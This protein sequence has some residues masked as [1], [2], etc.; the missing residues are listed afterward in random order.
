MKKPILRIS[1]ALTALLPSIAFSVTHNVLPD[2]SIQSVV[3]AASAGDQII[4]AGGSYS[5]DLTINKNL[6][7][8]REAGTS[9]HL[10]GNVTFSGITGTFVFAHF[11]VGSDDTKSLTITNCDN[12]FLEDVNASGGGGLNSSGSKVY[13]YDCSFGSATFSNS[14]WTMQECQITGNVSSSNSNTKILRCTLNG[15]LNHQTGQNFTCTVF[16]STVQGDI[17]T[18]AKRSWFGYNDL[19]AISI[20][21]S[22]EEAEIVGN[23]FI[24]GSPYDKIT[25]NAPSLVIYVRNNLIVEDDGLL[26]QA[27]TKIRVHNNIFFDLRKGIEV[28]PAAGEI[29]VIG[30]VFMDID[31]AVTAPFEAGGC[32]YN[33]IADSSS[34]LVSYYFV[35]GVVQSDN[36]IEKPSS[37]NGWNPAKFANLT[38]SNRYN[39]NDNFELSGNSPLKNAGSPQPEF[40]NHG[41]TRQDIGLYGGHHYDREGKTTDKP[42]ILSAEVSPNRIYNGG[43]GTIKIKSRAAVSTPKQ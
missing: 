2:Q 36:L 37:Q 18:V 41:G 21:G 3:N 19:Q 30:N 39:A 33:F 40:K 16:Q 42:V 35:G 32:Q 13:A 26:V 28:L 43:S 38:S 34:A 22:A 11:R 6:D 7:F 27:G 4:I 23:S 25:V 31:S 14:N 9:V 5:E 8:R 15:D 29:E 20:S 1:V 12:V 24:L 10:S 17:S